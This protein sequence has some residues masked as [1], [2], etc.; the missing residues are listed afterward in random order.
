MYVL[1]AEIIR[2]HFKIITIRGA[3]QE[4]I[5]TRDED[6]WGV[7][8]Q[9]HCFATRLQ[10]EVSSHP[11]APPALLAVKDTSVPI[12]QEDLWASVPVWIF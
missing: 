6:K 9:L 1:H 7:E 4:L 11:Y 3:K 8:V 5:C 10:I 2:L 12:D